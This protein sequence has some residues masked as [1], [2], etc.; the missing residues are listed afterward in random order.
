MDSTDLQSN[1]HIISISKILENI[2]EKVEGNLICDITPYN[3][4]YN[5]NLAKIKNLQYICKNKSKICEIGVN[6][7]H[8]LLLMVLVNPT[9]EYLLFDLNNH[10]YTEPCLDYIRTEFP[11]TKIN[12]IYGNSV[13]TIY[14]Y[15]K[16]NKNELNT[17]DF[18]HIDGGHTKDIFEHDFNNIKYLI[19][20]NKPVIFDDYNMNEIRQFINEKINNNEI[21]KYNEN[22][23]EKIDE[24]INIANNII[25][26]NLHFI[27]TYT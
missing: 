6:A 12:I 19:N 9:A 10:K 24:K 4:I 27:Y 3:F 5:D 18:C 25:D 2:D 15:I 21:I 14:N 16:N 7:C 8:S 22:G 11:N 17:Y 26:T 20:N 1:K 23:D 13:K